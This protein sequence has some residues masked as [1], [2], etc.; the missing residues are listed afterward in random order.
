MKKKAK[1]KIEVRPCEGKGDPDIPL[2][3]NNVIKLRFGECTHEAYV[4]GLVS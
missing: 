4:Y 1:E 2:T 3:V